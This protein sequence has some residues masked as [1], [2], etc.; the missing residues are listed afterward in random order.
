MD[1]WQAGTEQQRDEVEG[2]VQSRVCGRLGVGVGEQVHHVLAGE[3]GELLLLP[4]PVRSW[5]PMADAAPVV[6]EWGHGAPTWS[7]RGLASQWRGLTTGTSGKWRFARGV[8]EAK[9]DTGRH[10]AVFFG[11]LALPAVKRGTSTIPV[12]PVE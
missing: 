11:D 12:F 3:G 6:A 8:D 1:G 9:R 5:L 10:F 7:R 4:G 2:Q